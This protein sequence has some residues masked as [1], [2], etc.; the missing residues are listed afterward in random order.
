MQRRSR[1]RA[2]IKDKYIAKEIVFS[3]LAL[4]MYE[5][6]WVV[7]KRLVRLAPYPPDFPQPDHVTGPVILVRLYPICVVYDKNRNNISKKEYFDDRISY[8]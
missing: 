7:V 4:L 2:R 3:S 8:G 5:L 6:T 1:A